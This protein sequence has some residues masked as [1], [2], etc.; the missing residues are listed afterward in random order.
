[1]WSLIKALTEVRAAHADFCG[2]RIPGTGSSQGQK[3]GGISLRNNSQVELQRVG[4]DM[5]EWQR[6]SSE[7]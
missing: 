3:H 5:R 2:K 1:M 6:M 4:E 7:T